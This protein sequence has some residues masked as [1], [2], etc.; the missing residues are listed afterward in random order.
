[1]VNAQ[2]LDAVRGE[3]EQ[4]LSRS[5]AY[6][7]LAPEEQQR[8]ARDMS[9]VGS[10]LADK[11]WLETPPPARATALAEQDPIDTLKSRLAQKPGRWA[12]AS[13]PAPSARAWSSS[14]RW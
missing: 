7:A 13:R 9:K 3:V 12:T 8:L 14:A 10:Y 1:M 4:L 2:A 6:Q 5:Q 11:G